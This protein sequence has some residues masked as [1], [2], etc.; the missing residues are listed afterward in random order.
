MKMIILPYGKEGWTTLFG[1]CIYDEKEDV[2]EKKLIERG[3]SSISGRIVEV[4]T[5]CCTGTT[6][7][8]SSRGKVVAGGNH[9]LSNYQTHYNID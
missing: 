4:R 3:E 6:A 1:F 5:S 7:V 8:N 9:H 2:N